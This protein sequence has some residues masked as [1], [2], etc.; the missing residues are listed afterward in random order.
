MTQPITNSAS[1]EA[2]SAPRPGEP[3]R[4][5]ARSGNVDRDWLLCFSDPTSIDWRRD[6]G[7]PRHDEIERI[8]RRVAHVTGVSIS[9]I[10]GVSR[11]RDVA[12]ARQAVCFLSVQSGRSVSVVGRWLGKDHSTVI[13]GANAVKTRLK[14]GCQETARII[15]EAG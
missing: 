7:K 9:E 3:P 5:D 4:T 2:G 1:C 10:R 6:K 8:A 14:G 12:R 11:T 15:A 13:H